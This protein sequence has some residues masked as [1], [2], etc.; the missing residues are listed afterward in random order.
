MNDFES[1]SL[2]VVAVGISAFYLSLARGFLEIV[3]SD[4]RLVRELYGLN[5]PR[6]YS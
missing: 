1:L 4:A 3:E 5:A 2:L 6:F